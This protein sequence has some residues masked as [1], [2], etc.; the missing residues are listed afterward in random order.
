M[1]TTP[2][3]HIVLRIVSYIIGNKLIPWLKKFMI[4]GNPSVNIKFQRTISI[5]NKSVLVNDQFSGDQLSN[6]AAKPD[7][8]D[9]IVFKFCHSM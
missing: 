6:K 9:C 1:K 3:R 8:V 7:K 5:T 2:F 4:L